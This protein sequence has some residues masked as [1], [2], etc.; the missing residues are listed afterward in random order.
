M[1]SVL[2]RVRREDP[3]VLN[4]QAEPPHVE[5][6]EP[7]NPGRGKGHAIVRADR[8]G[9]PVLAKEPLEDRTH[10]VTLHREQAVARQEIPGVLV[11]D[12]Q[13]VAV[14]AIAGAEVA[15][16]VGGP[17]IV[18]LRGGRRHDARVLVLAPA[19][20]LLHQPPPGEQIPG[21]AD[22]RPGHA[23]MPRREPVQE[24]GGPPARMLPARRTDQGRD[25]RRDAVRTVMRGPAALLQPLPAGFV[26]ASEPLVPR[27]ATNAIPG[28]TLDH[29]VRGHSV[30]VNEPFALLHG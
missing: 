11:G 4:A 19:P 28:A 30:I 21:R 14:E 29:R 1:G 13:G 24:L 12:R 17:Q 8:P 20:P 6:G 16:E 9:Q 23:G 15:L 7:V 27:L 26:E 3:L 5:L 18:G 10:P 22:G 2:L 25:L